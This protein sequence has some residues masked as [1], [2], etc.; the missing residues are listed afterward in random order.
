[1]PDPLMIAAQAGF[2]VVG[3]WIAHIDIQEHRIP[4]RAVVPLAGGILVLSASAA[5]AEGAVALLARVLV[6]AIALGGFYAVLRAAS[7]G[8]LGGGDVK[9]AIPTG[10][11]LAWDGW[12]PL[13]AGGGL[14]FLIGGA[15]SFG[16]LA[17][18]GRLRAIRGVGCGRRAR[19]HVTYRTW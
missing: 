16:L 10:M 8:A 12:I 7:R 18:R 1:M 3:A 6:G 11:I 17:L 5:I 4:N 13:V 19:D 14:A 2:V 15:W 9:L